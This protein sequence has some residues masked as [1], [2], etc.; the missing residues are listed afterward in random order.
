MSGH[1]AYLDTETIPSQDP[2]IIGEIGSRYPVAD[3]DVDDVKPA[4]NLV[5]PPKIEADIAKKRA[6]LIEDRE[7]ALAKA[8]AARDK[9]YRDLSKHGGAGA[10]L[11]CIS[12]AIDGEPVQCF[13]NEALAKFDGRYSVPTFEEVLEGEREML[14][15]FFVNLRFSIT[16]AWANR[17][18]AAWDELEAKADQ[19]GF[20]DIGGGY[21]RKLPS[22]G[23]DA[24]IE[25]N[26][27]G[28]VYSPC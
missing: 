20:V 17:A 12:Y 2:A 8:E 23:R 9:D 22:A 7:A 25:E 16:D 15:T 4:A 11:A 3:V 24:W 27:C 1:F 10:H 21:V 5:D 14:R 6:K 26:V 28:C 19:S 18:L 13:R